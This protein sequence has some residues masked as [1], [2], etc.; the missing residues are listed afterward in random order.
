MEVV[1]PYCYSWFLYVVFGHQIFRNPELKCS[2]MCVP[3]LRIKYKFVP[4]S[5][6]PPGKH[7]Y[8]PH[9]SGCL[10]S[11]GTFWL[12]PSPS[13]YC[14]SKTSSCSTC[15]VH[16]GRMVGLY[17]HFISVLHLYISALLPS[18]YGY[19]CSLLG[20]VTNKGV[21]ACHERFGNL[22]Y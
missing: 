17:A 9:I 20:Y 14:I 4:V 22:L 21:T 10:F 8:Y 13:A 5:Q 3:V 12:P 6:V 16:S 11:P 2:A 18:D 1:I 15:T 19:V 7:T